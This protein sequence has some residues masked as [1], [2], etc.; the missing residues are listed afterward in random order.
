MQYTQHIAKNV[1]V[2]NYRDNWMEK[3]QKGYAFLKDL[4]DNGGKDRVFVCRN[5]ECVVYMGEMNANELIGWAEKIYN[6]VLVSK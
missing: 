4:E 1:I 3:Y 5:M 6:G 2:Y